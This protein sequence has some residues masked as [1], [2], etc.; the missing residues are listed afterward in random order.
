MDITVKQLAVFVAVAK[1]TSV[2]VAAEELYLSQPATSMALAELERILGD[3][4]FDRKGRKLHLN[5]KGRALLP[6]AVDILNRMNEVSEKFSSRNDKMV[7]DF[8]LGASTTVGN[9]V[10]PSLLGEFLELYP[11]VKISL[12]ISNSENIIRKVINFELDMAVIE[13]RCQEN[14]LEIIPW[15]KDRLCVFVGKNHALAGKE[16]ISKKDLESCDWI[17]R[18]GGSGSFETFENAISGKLKHL[19]IKMK[20]GNTEAIKTAVSAGLG[21]SCLSY[22]AIQSSLEQGSLVEIKT[23]F[24]NLDRQYYILVH[25]QKYRSDLLKTCLNFWQD[26]I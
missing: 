8:R 7:G 24:L 21:I 17:L 3:K 2:S 20:L 26:K 10:L 12:D 6:M 15:Q 23:P 11:E 4:F 18:E 19:K 1:N 9:Y 14:E 5:E 22:H 16:N 25:K 13:S